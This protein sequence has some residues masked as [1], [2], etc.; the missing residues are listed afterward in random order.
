MTQDSAD[1]LL[2]I[3]ILDEDAGLADVEDDQGRTFQLPAEWLP[4]AADGQGYRVSRTGAQLTLTPDPDAPRL[5]RERSKQTLLDFAD[6]PED[7]P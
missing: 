7:A 2:V 3:D 4:A 5:M 1:T 6:A